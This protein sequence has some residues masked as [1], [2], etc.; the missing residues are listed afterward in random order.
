MYWSPDS[1]YVAYAMTESN[2]DERG[3][4]VVSLPTEQVTNV[5]ESFPGDSRPIGWISSADAEP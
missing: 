4:A 2:E 1:Q 5:I 3:I